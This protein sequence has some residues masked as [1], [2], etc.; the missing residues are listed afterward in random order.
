MKWFVI[1]ITLF[2]QICIISCAMN[3]RIADSDT[4]DLV[5][6]RPSIQFFNKGTPLSPDNVVFIV[7]TVVCENKTIRDTFNFDDHTGTLSSY[8][9]TNTSFTLTIEAIDSS[10][11]IIYFGEQTLDGAADDTT[12]TIT[13]NEVS[14]HC[15]EDLT[16]KTI[17]STSVR[18]SWKDISTNENGFILKRSAVN[19]SS[20]TVLDTIPAD[21]NE[22]DVEEFLDST[23]AD[24]VTVYYYRLMAYNS[25]GISDSTT[26]KYDPLEVVTTPGKPSGDTE[27][28]KDA[29]YL[30]STD[31]LA[32]GNGHLLLYRFDWGDGKKSDWSF[33]QAA[34]HAWTKEGTYNIRVQVKC[35]KHPEVISAWSDELE[36]TVS[37][38]NY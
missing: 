20:F 11:Q 29:V 33:S 35:S 4:S 10:G 36:I 3:T 6:V 38:K 14:P 27:I 34:F 8:I 13:A 23:L 25:V 7:I 24:P 17:D 1:I 9:P 22:D 5:L 28:F 26:K 16:I 12:V 15:P 37:K 30:Y 21:S 18:L 19:Q 2:L 32:C 31:S